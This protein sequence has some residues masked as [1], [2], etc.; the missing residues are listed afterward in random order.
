MYINKASRWIIGG[1]GV[2]IILMGLLM[3]VAGVESLRM[4]RKATRQI[5]DTNDKYNRV[6]QEF[7]DTQLYNFKPGYHSRIRFG[8]VD[9][10]HSA[11]SAVDSFQS[12]QGSVDSFQSA[13][14]SVDSFQS[15]QGS[16]DSF[17]SAQGSVDSFK[18]AKSSSSNEE[19]SITN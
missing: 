9:S 17:Q 13:Q 2:L 10:Y 16:V 1:L 3:V 18:S 8:S 12:A 15:A 11:K 19:D 5:K 14:G 6:L 7:V 4:Q